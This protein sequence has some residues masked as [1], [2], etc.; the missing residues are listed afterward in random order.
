MEVFIDNWICMIS[1]NGWSLMGQ[2]YPNFLSGLGRLRL[3]AQESV[4]WLQCVY[5]EK[6]FFTGFV[7]DYC[8]PFFLKYWREEK[9]DKLLEH[10]FMIAIKWVRKTYLNN[11]L[12][13]KGKYSCL[14]YRRFYHKIRIKKKY[15]GPMSC[16]YLQ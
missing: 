11:F 13:Y 9:M 10:L 14:S 12:G 4:C 3:W 5:H 15:P 16:D 2:G 8:F 7:G 6:W 1:A